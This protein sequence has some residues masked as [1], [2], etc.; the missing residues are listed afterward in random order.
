MD[1]STRSTFPYPVFPLRSHSKFKRFTIEVEKVRSSFNEDMQ[2]LMFRNG[3]AL[4]A[5]CAVC[6]LVSVRTCIDLFRC[7]LSRQYPSGLAVTSAF[8]IQK[9]TRTHRPRVTA[10]TIKLVPSNSLLSTT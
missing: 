7:N 2:R 5:D 9:D 1:R 3:E 10:T 6:Y 8:A 4:I